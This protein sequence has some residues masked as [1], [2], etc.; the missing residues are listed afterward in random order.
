M[1]KTK[2]NKNKDKIWDRIFKTTLLTH[3]SLFVALV[4]LVF[5]KEYQ[6][7]VHITNL[8]TETYNKDN[9]K[10][11]FD[12]S[13]IID[14]ITYHFECQYTN[15]GAMVFRMFEYDFHI[16][17]ADAKRTNNFKEFTFP[18]SCVFYILPKESMPASLD[19]KINFQD[20]FYNYKV[21]VIRLYDYE[22]EDIEQN[23]LYLFLPYE[24][25]RHIRHVTT[26]RN[27]KTYKTEI[28]GV[29][30]KI[31]NILERAYK[32][33]KITDDELLT[34]LE[35]IK[36]TADYEL[37]AY[38]D[39]MKEVDHML[40]EDYEPKWKKE[41]RREAKKEAQKEVQ[42]VIEKMEMQLKAKAMK[43]AKAEAMKEAKAEAMK[44]AKAEAMK[45]VQKEIILILKTM[46]K[47]GIPTDDIRKVASE[48]NIPPELVDGLLNPDNNKEI[49]Q[50]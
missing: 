6:K 3:P 43:E 16:A 22:L 37:E 38:P 44:E 48:R 23:G 41:L 34:L 26:G 18:N 46:Y 39:I 8:N 29:Y 27:I 9:S 28:T 14:G 1:D 32:T 10:I 13:F 2:K 47:T 21:P 12:T 17:L 7:D 50:P 20:G 45:E 24:I 35:L 15:D 25:L 5:K 11:I 42:I 30:K 49:I 40:R 33:D 4:N 19:M 31:T 36:E